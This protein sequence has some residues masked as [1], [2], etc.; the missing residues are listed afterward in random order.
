MNSANAIQPLTV[1]YDVAKQ[2]VRY[3]EFQ[4]PRQLITRAVWNSVATFASVADQALRITARQPDYAVAQL[5][6]SVTGTSL[7]CP[8]DTPARA[9][10]S[11]TR[12]A[13]PKRSVTD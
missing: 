10:R 1:T 4:S 3:A 2:V 7:V 13:I 11:F 8:T 6:T 9:R 12:V 5:T